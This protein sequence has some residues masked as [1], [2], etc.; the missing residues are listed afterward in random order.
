MND[1]EIKKAI[2]MSGKAPGKST[3]FIRQLE[4]R[5][6]QVV[7]VIPNLS[8]V[9]ELIKEARDAAFNTSTRQALNE[10]LELLKG[11]K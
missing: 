5:G 10:A 6:I 11:G 4:A 7:E 8:Q 1:N 9:V 2:F 3:D